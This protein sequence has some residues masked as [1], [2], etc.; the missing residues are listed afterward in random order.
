MKTNKCITCKYGALLE[1]VSRGEI[2]SVYLFATAIKVR[3]GKLTTISYKHNGK[4]C[5][6]SQWNDKENKC[7]KN[8]YSEYEKFDIGDKFI[9][10]DAT[11]TD[12]SEL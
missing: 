5:R 2:K 3:D 7:L 10:V 1:G 8:D 12:A 4:G 9:T 6:M 11:T